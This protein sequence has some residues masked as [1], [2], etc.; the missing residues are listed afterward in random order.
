MAGSKGKVD[1]RLICP[2]CPKQIVGLNLSGT[3]MHR[4]QPDHPAWDV[5]TYGGMCDSCGA[6]MELTVT[7]VQD[8]KES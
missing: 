8:L 2:T 3:A 6:E 1:I 7:R 4:A 5:S